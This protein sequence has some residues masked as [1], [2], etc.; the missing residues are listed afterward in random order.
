[1]KTDSK[2]YTYSLIGLSILA[3][4]G[5]AAFFVFRK[6]GDGGDRNT[7]NDNNETNPLFKM[8]KTLVCSHI[9]NLDASGSS[10]A[11]NNLRNIGLNLNNNI[12]I[13]ILIKHLFIRKF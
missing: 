12:D 11:Q 3:V 1:M 13:F 8:L 9:C 5:I 10:P 6:K 4:G 2:L 7:N